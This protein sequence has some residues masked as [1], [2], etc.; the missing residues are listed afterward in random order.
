M[1][2]PDA[3]VAKV[4]KRHDRMAADAQHLLKHAE[5]MAGFLERLGQDDV[6]ERLFR[7]FG[8]RL[9]DVA[10]IDRDAPGDRF[11]NQ[12]AVDLDAARLHLLVLAQ[13]GQQRAVPASQVEHP[14]SGRNQFRDESKIAPSKDVAYFQRSV[15]KRT[16]I[17]SARRGYNRNGMVLYRVVCA[18]LLGLVFLTVASAKT[19]RFS[20]ELQAGQLYAKPLAGGLWFCLHPSADQTGWTVAVST[21][22]QPEAENFA[23]AATPPF[24]G[25]NPASLDSW[26]FLPG[27]RVF[28]RKRSFRFVLRREDYQTIMVKLND[29]LDAAE[30]LAD[31]DR[32]GRGEGE[33]E[34]LGAELDPAGGKDCPRLVRMKFKAT[35]IVPRDAPDRR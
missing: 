10:V 1:A 12:L 2:Q 28:S 3:P 7:V 32:L 24:H 14:R 19:F 11:L 13:P 26:H 35:L 6:I 22:C 18:S 29:R 16:S 34:V 25:P 30:I 4:R 27:A 21:S 17:V 31:I 23:A 20:G 33:I 5:R 15:S 9:V 8:H